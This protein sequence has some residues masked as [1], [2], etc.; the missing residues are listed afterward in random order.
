M[1]L[2]GDFDALVGVLDPDVVLR[3][4]GG[5]TRL[6]QHPRGAETVAGQALLWSRVDLSMRGALVNGA[7]GIV[8]FLNRRPFS[9]APSRS[10]TGR[11]AEI[12][13]LADAVGAP[14][15][16]SQ[17]SATGASAQGRG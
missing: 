8:T 15:S 9:I 7:A 6:S 12:H 10:R 3:A 16:T 14:S 11:I 4:D 5:L 2:D 1:P 17:S 13:F